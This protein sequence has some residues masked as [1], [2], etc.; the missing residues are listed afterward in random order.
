M[1]TTYFYRGQIYRNN[2]LLTEP[3][4]RGLLYGDGFFETFRVCEGQIPL[5]R[6]HWLRLQRSLKYF[7]LK[8]IDLNQE[9]RF[10]K[11]LKSLYP[12]AKPNL[13][14]RLSVWRSGQGKGY[15]PPTDEE[16]DYLLAATALPEVFPSVEKPL[17]VGILPGKWRYSR[18]SYIKSCSSS[19]LVE[20]SRLAQQRGWQE[21]LLKNQ[22]ERLA[23]GLTGNLFLWKN[24]ELLTPACA[25]GALP[26]VMRQYLIQ[27]SKKNGYP[28]RIGKVFVK[29]F[30]EAQAAWLSNSIRFLRPLYLK[31]KK[32]PLKASLWQAHSLQNLTQEKWLK[33]FWRIVLWLPKKIVIYTCV[34]FRTLKNGNTHAT[35]L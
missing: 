13:R 31:S 3:Y 32:P 16:L 15:F 10:L 9:G 8:H 18:T 27:F 6:G 1:H 14:V 19:A 34:L 29:D 7:G 2:S 28:I 23:E 22:T 11:Q 5:W 12:S 25:E 33:D 30:N 35:G 26:G 24:D 21:A 4:H 17:K 20:A